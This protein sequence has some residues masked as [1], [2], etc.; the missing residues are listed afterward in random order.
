[1]TAAGQAA[2]AQPGSAAAMPMLAR[3]RKGVATARA[4]LPGP[5]VLVPT[6][7]ALHDGHRPPL[8]LARELAGQGGSVVVSIFVNPLQFGPTEDFDRYPRSLEVLFGRRP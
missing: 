4:T 1:M 6:M 2:P 8:R 3:T 7:G 5:V